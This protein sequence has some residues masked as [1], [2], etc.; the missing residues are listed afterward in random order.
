MI[1]SWMVPLGAMGVVVAL[2]LVRLS[3]LI[4]YIPNNR[5][6]I[7][8]K[9]VSARGSVRTGLI[10]LNGETGFQPNVLRGG[11]HLF[12]PLQYRVH[13]ASLVTIPQGKIGYI[14]ARDGRPLDP[15][16]ALASNVVA[17]DF[18]DTAGFLAAGGAARRAAADLSRRHLYAQPGAVRGADRRSHLFAAAGEGR[19][20]GVSANG[21]GDRRAR[22]LR[23]AGAERRRRSGR[24]CHRARRTV[25]AAGRDHRA[26]GGRRSQRSVDLSQQL[27]GPR[28]L[29]ARGRAPRPAAPRAGGRHLLFESA[30]RHTSRRIAKVDDRRRLGGRGGQ[31]HRRRRR[32]S[33][34]R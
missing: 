30:V 21:H 5:I 14:F 31:L 7:L 2:L 19:A 22:R 1:G 32:R 17:S 29:S 12:F 25:A 13:S 9:L 18:Q 16:Q 27:S 24:H 26:H 8:E 6:G 33:V 20:G 15:T 28:A 34:G 3:G 11:W 23:A 4:R 10:A